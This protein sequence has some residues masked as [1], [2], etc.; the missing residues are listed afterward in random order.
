M[1][2][3]S[4]KAEIVSEE[5]VWKLKAY[6]K[7]IAKFEKSTF[8]NYA[9]LKIDFDL[10]GVR[11]KMLSNEKY[12]NSDINILDRVDFNLESRHLNKV[13]DNLSGFNL[14]IQDLYYYIHDEVIEPKHIKF[15]KH[16]INFTIGKITLVPRKVL[17]YS[18]LHQIGLKINTK[19]NLHYG[20]SDQVFL[21]RNDKT[22]DITKISCGNGKDLHMI[23][24]VKAYFH[25]LYEKSFQVLSTLHL[26]IM[27]SDE[28]TKIFTDRSYKTDE[29]EVKFFF[30]EFKENSFISLMQKRVP[31][32][33]KIEIELIIE[34]SNGLANGVDK[35]YRNAVTAGVLTDNTYYLRPTRAGHAMYREISKGMRLAS[36][37]RASN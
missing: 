18:I 14:D 15:I 32:F 19:R 11:P 30:L 28:V 36:F 2:K 22:K 1:G 8:Q 21:I 37:A 24:F 6:Y 29:I 25:R 5:E 4:S 20:L 33:K 17:N 13:Y 7:I 23:K 34:L 9:S 12:V 35:V 27:T 3:S 16:F 31:K 10:L 26:G